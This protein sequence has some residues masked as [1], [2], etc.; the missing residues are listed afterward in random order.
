M[1]KT[2]ICLS[3]TLYII[4]VGSVILKHFIELLIYIHIF[5]YICT[6]VYL[7][8]LPVIIHFSLTC[9]LYTVTLIKIEMLKSFMFEQQPA[10]YGQVLKNLIKT[11]IDGERQFQPFSCQ[12]ERIVVFQHYFCHYL[13]F[14]NFKTLGETN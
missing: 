13:P 7:L 2:S 5:I 3:L 10:S 4:Q 1:N 6:Y 9:I 12:L 14:K 11:G 8:A